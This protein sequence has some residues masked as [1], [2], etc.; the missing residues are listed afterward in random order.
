M[1]A[2]ELIEKLNQTIS[3]ND[4]YIGEIAVD[5]D[6]E[7]ISE[8]METPIKHVYQEGGHEGGGDYVCGV[9][10]FTEYDIYL[11]IEGYYCSHNGTEFDDDWFQVF[12]KQKM[13]TVY[14]TAKETTNQNTDTDGDSYSY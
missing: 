2:K 8:K 9:I 10:H 1:E 7:E 6:L 4:I 12:P 5:G 3:D 14:E 13:I 11:K